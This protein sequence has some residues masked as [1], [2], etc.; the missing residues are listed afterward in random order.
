[1]ALLLWGLASFP[2]LQAQVV[3]SEFLAENHGGLIDEDGDHSDW[4]E[5]HNPTQETIDL[6]KWALT[7]KPDK[8]SKWLFPSVK[9]G[10]EQFLVVFASGKDHRNPQKPLHANFK[11]S[12]K[13]DYLGLIKADGTTV[14]FE[15]APQYPGQRIDV[16]Y[17]LPESFFTRNAKAPVGVSF[18]ALPTPG[19]ANRP[20][21]GGSPPPPSFG[22]RSGLYES[23]L[24]VTLHSIA[25]EV[26]IYYTTNGTSPTPSN[27]LAYRA[28]LQLAQN[29]VLRARSFKPNSL[30]SEIVTR[31]FLFVDA[32][33]QQ[34]GAGLPSTWGVREGKPVV[35]DYEMDPEIVTN[36]IYATQAGPALSALS[37][38]SLALDPH[39][40]FDP[41]R[42]IYA[43]PMEAGPDWERHGVMEW[44]PAKGGA[45]FAVECG[46]RIQG[47]WNR[48]PEECPKHSLRLIFR[49]RHNSDKLH[50]PLFGDGVSEFEEVV[51]R[52]GCN[53][54]WL[55]WSGEERARGDYLRD[56]WMRD[57]YAAMGRLSAR[58]RFV[59]LFLNGLYWGIYN[60][61]E[62]P[63]APFLAEH[64]GGKE[65]DYE[66]RNGTNVLEGDAKVWEELMQCVNGGLESPEAYARL[67]GL[68]DLPAFTDY[69]ILNLYGANADYDRS[70]NWYAARS[71][72][73]GGRFVFIVWDGER[74][75]EDPT[76]NTL[77]YDED[78]S[79]ARIF[80]KL[81][82]NPAFR[83]QFNRRVRELCR[84]DGPLSP[85]SAGTRYERLAADLAPAI[86]LESARW[87]DYRRDVHRYK[88]EPYELYM[89]E[90]HWKPE[91]QRLLRDY[92][93]K[94]TAEFL[95]QLEKAG[96]VK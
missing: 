64:L 46:V 62:R 79:P 45:G 47:G 80:Q 20:G 82:E 34:T 14:A 75:L 22:E 57:T 2:A 48:R 69:M 6:E 50:H 21:I 44:L 29:T 41:T 32:T 54:T 81:R 90:T 67:E 65:G 33:L 39:D 25:P 38:V 19:Q 70:S 36:R 60:L 16:S 15:F 84:D 35:A 96:L 18:L 27:G 26:T 55:H 87:G 78:Q 43:N 92:F 24:R 4:I 37:A 9:L 12:K 49:K 68:L 51:L 94:R 76:S 73:P 17:G 8:K 56:Q 88:T 91:I 95:S 28:P 3:I 93:P 61:V 86:V 85:K 89:P 58:G 59:H 53:N 66:V 83:E 30:A 63:S 1:M 5:L 13:G 31:T 11:L 7:D 77:R 40:L 23:P 52:G 42:G 71:R 74:T 10:P 72:K